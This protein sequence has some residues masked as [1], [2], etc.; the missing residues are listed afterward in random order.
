MFPNSGIARRC[1]TNAEVFTIGQLGNRGIAVNAYVGFQKRGVW[2]MSGIEASFFISVIM[3]AYNMAQY[4]ARAIDSVQAQTH[5]NWELLIIDDGSTDTTVAVAQ[6]YAQNDARIRIICQEN[7]GVA[8]AR[9]TGLDHAAG[10]YI[11]FIDSDDYYEPTILEKLAARMAQGNCDLVYC[12]T[13]HE[14]ENKIQGAPYPE[15]NLLE[16]YASGL[17]DY[18]GLYSTLTKKS[19]LAEHGIRFTAGCSVGEDQEFLMHCG[20][21]ARVKSVPEVLYHYCWNQES[22]MSTMT[23][24]KVHIDLA[25]RQRSTALV[26]R[27]YHG[28]HKK[29]IVQFLQS[30]EDRI[31]II[32]TNLV[33]QRIKRGDLAGAVQE[34]HEFGAIPYCLRSRN[35]KHLKRALILNSGSQKLWLFFWGK[36]QP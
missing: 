4:I 25:S 9:N 34:V 26:E 8:A 11:A 21:Y 19:F 20:I 14:K 30:W 7:Q 13:L 12:G 5:E 22:V 18:I 32:F 10:D 2:L 17:V 33:V 15:M 36:K 23:P 29:K 16:C 35:F 6:G 24:Q 1:S 31:V 28:L 27:E 3:P